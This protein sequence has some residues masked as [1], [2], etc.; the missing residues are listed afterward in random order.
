[1]HPLLTSTIM[2]GVAAAQTTSVMSLFLPT[3]AFDPQPLVGSIVTAAP[4]RIEYFVECAPDADANDCGVGPGISVTMQPGTY[5]LGMTED[6]FLYV[7]PPAYL[8][9]FHSYLVT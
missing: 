3:Y 8:S 5:A 9:A 1:M 2:A 4:T 7:P 6:G